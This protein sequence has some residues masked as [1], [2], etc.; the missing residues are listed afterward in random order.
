M[1]EKFTV[2]ADHHS[3]SWL[4][5]IT[6]PS[7]RLK[8]LRLILAE[9]DFSVAYKAGKD[10]HHDD[11][12]SCLLTGSPAIDLDNDDDLPTFVATVE[13]DEPNETKLTDKPETY[14]NET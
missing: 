6:D 11:C 13:D 12:L 4:F 9:L 8:R 5:G 7:G 3:L 10:N 2:H 14:F 1:F